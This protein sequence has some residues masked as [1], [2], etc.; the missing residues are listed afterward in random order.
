MIQGKDLM[1]GN[2]VE[3]NGYYAVVYSIFGPY[4]NSDER[5]NNKECVDLILGGI[6]TVTIDEINPVTLT[7]E[8][9]LKCGFIYDVDFD[10]IVL[11]LDC[12]VSFGFDST[13]LYYHGNLESYWVDI[14]KEVKYIHELQNIIFDLTGQELEIKL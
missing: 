9:L 6:A 12:G 5:F 4:P 11:D 1:K 7:E 3:Y 13:I 8:I 10:G 2:I 14:L